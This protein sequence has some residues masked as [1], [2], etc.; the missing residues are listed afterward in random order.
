MPV[1]RRAARAG[2]RPKGSGDPRGDILRAAQKE[3]GDHGYDRGS[4][5]ALARRAGV[6]PALVYHYFQSK[7]NLFRECLRHTMRDPPDVASALKAGDDEIGTVVVRM[8]LDRLSGSP[9][10]MAFRGLLRSTS[11]SEKA[12]KIFRDLIAQQITPLVSPDGASRDSD[13]R[14]ALAA[15]ALMGAGLVRSVVRLPGLSLPSVEQV[16]KWIGPT[17]TRY[18][19]DPLPS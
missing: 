3:F 14:V 5:R 10:S 7:N 1:N 6:N 16:A 18:L 2:R 15:S 19:R 12:A 9:D 4:I 13:R 11:T 8:F 17:L